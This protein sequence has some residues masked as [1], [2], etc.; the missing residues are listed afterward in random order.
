MKYVLP[1]ILLLV[2]VLVGFFVIARARQDLVGD[3][4]IRKQRGP[5]SKG[6]SLHAESSARFMELQQ[7][8]A[9]RRAE[10]DAKNAAGGQPSPQGGTG[11]PSAPDSPGSPD[12]P[13]SPRAEPGAEVSPGPATPTGA[14]DGGGT[15]SHDGMAARPALGGAPSVDGMPAGGIDDAP[16]SRGGAGEG[17]ASEG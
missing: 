8:I 5:K 13:G 16:S 15:S 14:G 12:A 4:S 3:D 9:L 11:V 1:T 6:T 2:V 17:E 7:E 10:L